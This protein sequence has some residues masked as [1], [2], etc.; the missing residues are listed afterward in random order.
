M[1]ESCTAMTTSGRP[2]SLRQAISTLMPL[3][4]RSSFGLPSTVGSVVQKLVLANF[5]LLPL[6]LPADPLI[7]FASGM[8]PTG[9]PE[10]SQRFT[11]ARNGNS[12]RAER[13]MRSVRLAATASER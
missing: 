11:S 12:A 13:A 7:S 3:T 6:Q 2:V 10:E 4:P 5:H 8:Q 9:M 1:P